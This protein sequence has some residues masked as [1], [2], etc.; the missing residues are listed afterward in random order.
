MKHVFSTSCAVFLSLLLMVTSCKKGDTGPAGEQ[1]EQ[2]DPGPAGPQGPQGPP[3]TANVI[4]S[5]WLDVEFQGVDDTTGVGII[6]AP[7]VTAEILTEGDVKTYWNIGTPD[8]PVVVSLPYFDNGLIFGGPGGVT[9]L[10]LTPIYAVGQIEVYS[11]Y[12]LSSDV[13]GDG[14]PVGQY[15]YIVIPGGT[16][17]R[18]AINWNDYNSVK[19]Y[20][21]LKD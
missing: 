14:D 11:R 6:E 10:W 7:E 15:R 3:G 18:S 5:E 20:L 2:G 21:K 17:A 8:D 1:G 12:D 16:P 4:Y 9:D 13:N 19:K